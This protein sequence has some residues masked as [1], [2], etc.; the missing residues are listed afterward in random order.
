MLKSVMP[1][2]S[3]LSEIFSYQQKLKTLNWQ[4]CSH[5]IITWQ[6][7]LFQIIICFEYLSRKKQV[8]P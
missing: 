6:K 1:Q 3:E 5:H 2:L 7:Y 4:P 8:R